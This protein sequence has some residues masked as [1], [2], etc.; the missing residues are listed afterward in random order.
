MRI[1]IVYPASAAA[2]NVLTILGL[3]A[4]IAELEAD[5]A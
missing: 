5:H 3:Q 4:R 1:A 2:P